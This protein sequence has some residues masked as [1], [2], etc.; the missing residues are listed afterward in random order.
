MTLHA[1][2]ANCALAQR[3]EGKRRT[4]RDLA[5]EEEG[6][7]GP[8]IFAELGYTGYLTSLEQDTGESK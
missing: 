6:K 1:T 4:W 7:D 5:Q 8:R 3:G 2:Q